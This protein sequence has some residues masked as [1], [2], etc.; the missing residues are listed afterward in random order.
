M[1]FQGFGWLVL[2][3][4]IFAMPAYLI[5][6]ER[7]SSLLGLWSAAVYFLILD[8]LIKKHRRKTCEEVIT[9]NKRGREKVHFVK[10]ERNPK[11][12]AKTETI[13]M[14]TCVFASIKFWRNLFFIGGA[15]GFLFPGRF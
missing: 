11:T 9:K 13:M 3:A 5:P 8:Y 12:G 1:I 10:V 14:D 2:L 7:L 4:P 6:N 15:W